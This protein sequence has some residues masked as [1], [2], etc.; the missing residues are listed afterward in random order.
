[1]GRENQ[2]CPHY[3]IIIFKWINTTHG[4][5]RQYIRIITVWWKWFERQKPEIVTKI[6][7]NA[8]L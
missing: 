3:P 8:I 7:N 5:I 1:M 6:G 4:H 2:N